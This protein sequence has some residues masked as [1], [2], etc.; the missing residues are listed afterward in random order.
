MPTPRS[1]GFLS[2]YPPTQCGL[3]TFTSS[4]AGALAEGPFGPSVGVVRVCER[5]DGLNS[6]AVIGLLLTTEPHGEAATAEALNRFETVIVQHEYGIYGGHDGESVVEVIR[7]LKVPSIVVLH[8][9]LSN[10]THHQRTVL[11]HVARAA[12]AVVVMTDTARVRLLE[13]YRVEAAKVQIIAHGAPTNWVGAGPATSTGTSSVL[14]WGLLGPGKGV[15]WMIDALPVL[16]DIDPPVIYTVAG[17]THPNVLEHHGEAYRNR[18]KKRSVTLKVAHMLRF[19]NRYLDEASLGALVR[20]ADVVVLPYDSTDQVTSGV[21][22]EAVSALRPVVATGFPHAVELLS[23]GAGTI[24]DH[25]DPT[26]MANAVRSILT[27]PGVAESMRTSAHALIS[28]LSWS[29]VAE[30]YRSLSIRL[31]QD[32]VPVVA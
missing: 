26:G 1:F 20:E 18:L 3:A 19:E 9:V 23:S 14:T 16:K 30:R 4:L 13:N 22:I 32:A 10:P 8:T 7:R 29:A 31:Q 2:T 6:P 12:S 24:V 25:R 21:L 11:E 15:E 27:E 28:D 5:D 17:E